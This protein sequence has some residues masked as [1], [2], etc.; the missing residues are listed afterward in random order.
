MTLPS[1]QQSWLI[2]CAVKLL[3]KDQCKSQTLYSPKILRIHLEDSQKTIT[4][5]A[6]KMGRKFFDHG[7]YI[8]WAQTQWFVFRLHCFW[9][10][11]QCLKQQWFPY[12]EEPSSSFKRTR[13]FKGALWQYDKWNKCTNWKQGTG[14]DCEKS[15]QS[16]VLLCYY[17]L[18]S[19][20]QS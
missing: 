9:E 13:I 19:W 2:V 10:E 8:P 14:R 16:K 15:T 7:C 12:M 11:W 4:W 20:C 18:H 6:W 5:E 17:G 3:K 1:G